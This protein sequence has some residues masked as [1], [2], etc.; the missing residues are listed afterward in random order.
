MS[1]LLE[2]DNPAQACSVSCY[3][4]SNL[5][6][7]RGWTFPDGTVCKVKGRSSDQLSF[8][9]Q[10]LNWRAS[11]YVCPT[12]LIYIGSLSRIQLFARSHIFSAIRC[13]SR[14]QEQQTRCQEIGGHQ[15]RR[16]RILLQEGLDHVDT[17]QQMQLLVS[18]SSTWPPDDDP[19]VSGTWRS[20]YFQR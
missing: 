9:I 18:S 14:H 2:H 6:V 16:R 8:C 11:V 7:S 5:K 19:H 13:V 1:S 17:S 12:C 3:T 10:V 15:S 20:K 4:S